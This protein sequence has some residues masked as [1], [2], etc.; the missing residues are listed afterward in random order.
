MSFP[1][2]LEKVMNCDSYVRFAVILDHTGNPLEQR[3]KNDVQNFLPYKQMKMS[4][5]HAID[6]WNFRTSM[7]EFL[8]NSKYV[9]AVYDNVRRIIIPINDDCLLL[10]V[11]D[12]RGGQKNII[13]RILAIISG[14]YTL[15]I[16][17]SPQ[18]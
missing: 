12:N 5:K 13:D 10:V 6:A 17:P 11:V 4:F 15:S 14:D 3:I 7:V 1:K 9:L 18:N 16:T 2:L 8:G